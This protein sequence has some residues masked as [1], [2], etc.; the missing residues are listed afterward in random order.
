MSRSNQPRTTHY[1]K[2]GE[3]LIPIWRQAVTTQDEYTS[4]ENYILDLQ[5]VQSMKLPINEKA[6]IFQ[7]NNAS[8]RTSLLHSMPIEAGE[9]L[10]SFQKYLLKAYRRTPVD[11]RERLHTVKRDDHVFITYLLCKSV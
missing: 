9:S 4:L 5:F 10:D 8:G 1:G 2:L 7:S 6:L 11:L 3:K